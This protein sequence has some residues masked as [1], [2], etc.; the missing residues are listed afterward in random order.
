MTTKIF[1]VFLM[2]HTFTF[3]I[4]RNR[5]VIKKNENLFSLNSSHNLEYDLGMQTYFLGL[6]DLSDWVIERL[7]LIK[8]LE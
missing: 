7:L 2:F 5:L 6:N 8:L 4:I 1:E 3:I